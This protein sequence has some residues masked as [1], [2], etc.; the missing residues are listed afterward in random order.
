MQRSLITALITLTWATWRPPAVQAENWPQFRG[1]GTGVAADAKLP[2]QWSQKKNVAWKVK[3]PGVGWSQPIVWGDKIFV[4]TAQ[5]NKQAAPDPKNTGPGFEGLGGFLASGG[6]KPPDDR[7]RW[8]VL[9]LD[10]ATGQTLWEQVARSGRPATQIH[11]NNTYATETPAT[12]GEVVIAYFGM[13]GVFCYNLAGEPLWQKD[14]GAYPTQFGW[15]PGSSP[16]LFGDLV[17]IQCDNDQESFLVALNKQTGDQV[18]RVDREEKSNWSTP[19]LWRNKQ[20]TE[21]IAAGGGEM[22]SYDPAT[23]DLLWSMEASGRTAITP[24]GDDELLYVDSANRLTG[25]IGVLAAV[26]AGASG[27]ISI[28][29]EEPGHEH[30]AWHVEF[31]GNRIASPLLY[32]GCLYSLA[33]PQGVVRCLDAAT[34]KEH[35]R[36]RLRGAAGFTA[37]P[38]AS[39]GRI[40]CLSENGATLILAAGP[41][42][43]VLAT[44]NLHEMCWATPAVAA[45][46]LLIRTINRLYC[47]GQD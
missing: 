16:L 15:G 12:D 32:E 34:G 35:Y 28:N 37:S 8:R 39:G 18:W 43:K 14:L 24:V 17:Y 22:R 33:Q 26:R 2:T 25:V 3:L 21:L 31:N 30:V 46:R 6:L 13:T 36:K 38:I 45:N 19:Y 44:N 5:T 42:L 23:G 10:A 47:L 9:C 40:Y 27:K 41:K 29:P 7:Y 4:T 11:P 1:D 20:R